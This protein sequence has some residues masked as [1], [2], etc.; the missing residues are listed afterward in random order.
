MNKYLVIGIKVECNILITMCLTEGFD[1][2][3][4]GGDYR[5]LY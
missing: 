4:S 1:V 3:L 5:K 2:R